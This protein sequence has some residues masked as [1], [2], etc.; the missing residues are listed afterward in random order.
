[1]VYYMVY[2]N[3]A[4]APKASQVQNRTDHRHRQEDD[5]DESSDQTK[6]QDEIIQQR[7]PAVGELCIGDLV[8]IWFEK[9]RAKSSFIDQLN[10]M[11]HWFVT[12]LTG[13]YRCTNRR[14]LL[15]MIGASEISEELEKRQL[16]KPALRRTEEKRRGRAAAR[17]QTDS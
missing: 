2:L 4:S 5:V 13:A 15:R 9:I 6:R 10:S 12:A 7:V 1:M 11:Q 14:K 3:L 16:E 8:W 17:L